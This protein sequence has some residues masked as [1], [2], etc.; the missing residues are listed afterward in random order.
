VSA[1]A[2]RNSCWAIRVG[3]KAERITTV[4]SSVYWVQARFPVPAQ[5][6]RVD[7]RSGQERQHQRARAGQER[8]E[9]WL[10]HVLLDAGDVPG[11]RADHDL[12]QRRGHRD[13]DADHRGEQ[14]AKTRRS[15]I[16]LHRSIAVSRM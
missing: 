16:R 15:F 3:T 2:G 5:R 6:H 13:P 11:Q 9:N 14:G 10:G 8:H 7:L 4:T 1:I 12:H